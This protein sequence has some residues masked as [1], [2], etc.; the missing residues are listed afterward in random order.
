MDYQTIVNIASEHAQQVIHG[1]KLN[2]LI[3]DEIKNHAESIIQSSIEEKFAEIKENINILN[4]QILL[5]R[6]ILETLNEK[7]NS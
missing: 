6:D 2:D 4:K 1:M 3:K 7:D 5:L